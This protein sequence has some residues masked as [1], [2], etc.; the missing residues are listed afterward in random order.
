[1]TKREIFATDGELIICT[2]S[3]EDRKDYVE[4]HRQL[5]GE[6]SLY[7]NPRSKDMMWEQTLNHEESI[8]SLFTVDGDYCGSIELQHSDSNTPEIGIDLLESKRNKGIAPKAVRLFSKRVCEEKKVDY[9]LIRIS[10]ANLHSQHVFEK[11]GAVKIGEE[12]S[13]FSKFVVRFGEI[14]GKSE[15]DLEDYKYLF[16]ENGDEVVYR[17]RLDIC[18]GYRQM[19]TTVFTES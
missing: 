17:Y 6:T 19:K 12:E 3:D 18:Q 1:M 2:L 9:F 10:S 16:G 8:F 7:L 5:N 4:L 13:I 14:A 15:Q 11:L